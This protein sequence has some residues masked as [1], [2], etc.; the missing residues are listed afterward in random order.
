M[1]AIA[2]AFLAFFWP[3]LTVLGLTVLWGGYSFV[4]GALAMTGAIS[5]KPGTARAWLSLIAIASI[6]CAGAVLV[7][8]EKVAG[9]LVAIISTWAIFT[10]A[11]QLWAALKL[12]KAVT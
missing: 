6:A 9:H 1:A 11:M 3:R 7:A 12:R 10:G 4:D 5:G 2:F 8:P